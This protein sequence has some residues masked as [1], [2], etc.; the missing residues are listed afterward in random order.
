MTLRD[1]LLIAIAAGTLV[2]ASNRLDATTSNIT[3]TATGT[4]ASTPNSGS[5]ALKLAGQPFTVAVTVAATT[6]PKQTG[7]TGRCTPR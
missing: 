2:T 1:T 6:Q 7:K 4:F 3:Y 5:D